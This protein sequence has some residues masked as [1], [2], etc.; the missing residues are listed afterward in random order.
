MQGSRPPVAAP[1]LIVS[2]DG[3]T[4]AACNACDWHLDTATW[5]EATEALRDHERP[6]PFC[7]CG[8]VNDER[9]EHGLDPGNV[10]LR[11]EHMDPHRSGSGLV[12]LRC[13]A[14]SPMF[15]KHFSIARWRMKSPWCVASVQESDLREHFVQLFARDPHVQDHRT[16]IVKVALPRHPPVRDVDGLEVVPVRP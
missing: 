14:A 12:W 9:A 1:T 13:V 11:Q 4:Q 7:A 5:D 16:D 2:Q 6:L 8:R 3:S 10:R 15:C